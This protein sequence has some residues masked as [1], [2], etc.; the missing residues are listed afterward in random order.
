LA[1]GSDTIQ[2]RPLPTLG[3]GVLGVVGGIVA[4]IVAVITVVLVGVLI[5]LTTLGGLAG[6]WISAG[7]LT[8]AGLVLLFVV[9]LTF[10][11]QIVVGLWIGNFAV[12]DIGAWPRALAAAAIGLAVIV[13]VVHVPYA[14]QLVRILV[15][16]MGVGGLL[17]AGWARRR[18]ADL[19][20]PPVPATEPG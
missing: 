5:G 15:V 18:R 3:V 19:P 2:R 20:P 1:A 17:L 8:I 7:G 4:I 11:A 16:L 12:R 10:L 9:A 6:L 13:A 14:G